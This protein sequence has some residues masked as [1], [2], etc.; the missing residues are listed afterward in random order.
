MSGYKL[1]VDPGNFRAFPVLIAAEYN[2]VAIEVPEFKTGKDNKTPAFLAKSPLGRVPVLETP[3][4]SIFESKA[5]ARYV[6]RLRQDTQLY[7]VSFFDGGVVDSWVDFCAHEIEL[8]ASLWFYP[9]LGY[10]PFNAT[11]TGKAKE[12]LAKAL[13]VLEKHLADKTYL[14]GHKITLADIVVVSALLYPFKFVADAAYR[15]PFPNVM[16]WFTT[17]VNQPAFEAVVGT[18]VLAEKEMT[19]SGAAVVP[20]KGSGGGN[21]N[22]GQQQ[23]QKPKQEKA[24]KAEKPKVTDATQKCRTH[25]RARR[26]SFSY[27]LS[28]PPVCVRADRGCCRRNLRRRR[29]R[30]RRRR[31]TTTTA[32]TSSPWRRRPS[33]PSRSWIRYLLSRP[34]SSRPLSSRPWMATLI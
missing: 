6:A 11:A 12:D 17:C 9:V 8:P 4:G 33:T 25:F 32:T 21:N 2:G 19:A 34:L 24:P 18:V 30:R 14:V 26:A 27:S 3:A 20:L 23:Q 5:I 1:H 29:S 22:K 31:T 13:G 16:R 7:G 10:I 15:K 28:L